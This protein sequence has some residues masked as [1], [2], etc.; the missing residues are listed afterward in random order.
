[1]SNEAFG[2]Y[3]TSEKSPGY[4]QKAGVAQPEF[5]LIE[6]GGEHKLMRPEELRQLIKTSPK[7]SV[8]C[9]SIVLPKAAGSEITELIDSTDSASKKS[10]ARGV[11]SSVSVLNQRGFVHRDIKPA[12][13]FFDVDTGKSTLIAVLSAAR[14]KIADY[15]FTTLVPNL[16]VVRRPSGDGT[17]FADI[18]G[19][20]AGASQGAGLGHDF[21]RHIE[22]TRLLVHVLDAS[23]PQLL[24]DYSV[25]EG[26]LGAYGHQLDQRPRLVVLN[27]IELVDAAELEGLKLQ[28]EQ[29]AGRPVLLISAAMASGLDALL[30][31]VWSELGIQSS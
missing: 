31:S 2:A 1:M 24:N 6:A 8:K 15:P 4:A 27:K 11:L 14:P 20:I 25:V 22:R 12:N 23:S 30:A 9:F 10:A 3:L 19:L 29:H 18:P 5:F 26:E 7:N 28:L 13:A 21:L 16:G 17:V